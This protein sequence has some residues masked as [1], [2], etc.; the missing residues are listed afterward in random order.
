MDRSSDKEPASDPM[1]PLVEEYLERLQRG[2]IV[3][4]EEYCDQHP[5]QADEICELF[6]ALAVMQELQPEPGATREDHEE[7]R[8]HP[9]QIGDYRILA[10]IGRGRTCVSIR[11]CILSYSHEDVHCNIYGTAMQSVVVDI[12]KYWLES[13]SCIA[14]VCSVCLRSTCCGVRI[15]WACPKVI[16]VN[17]LIVIP[18]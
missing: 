18:E 14:I 15:V 3:S 11:P 2:E 5:E 4:I 12:L 13:D 16:T 10:E 7:D 8:E 9:Q 17:L 1:L 6:P